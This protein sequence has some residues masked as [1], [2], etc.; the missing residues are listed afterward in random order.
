MDR[1]AILGMGPVGVSIGLALQ[2][3]GLADT[4]TVGWDGD[5]AALSTASKLGAIDSQHRSPRSA[6]DGAQL[7]VIDATVP[8]TETLLQAVG[9]VLDPGCVV[10]DTGTSKAHI[11]ELA[12]KHLADGAIYIGSRPLLSQRPSTLDEAT[13]SLFEGV[14]YCIIAGESADGEAVGTV[15]GMV[16]TLGARPLFI[17]A[18]E[19]DSYEAAVATLPAV[20]SYALVNATSSSPAW[21]ETSRFAGEE[22]GQLAKLAALDPADSAAACLA[23]RDAL[24]HWID[25]AISVLYS[26]RKDIDSGSE[27]LAVSFIRAWEEREK[28]EA[29]ALEDREGPRAPSVGET[30]QGMFL[31]RRLA[32]RQR[33]IRDATKRAPGEYQGD[34]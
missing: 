18:G 12:S 32:E 30:V 23:N 26:Y 2:R 19:H 11:A 9:P 3:A 33:Q 22:Y 14:E 5:R 31:G 4:E 8:E 25:Q 27:N 10:T 6:V 24:L 16:E 20:L 28:W 17:D 15:V 13:A 21:R 7:V 1:I 34:K 29:G